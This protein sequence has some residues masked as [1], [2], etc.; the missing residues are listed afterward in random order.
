MSLK[1][2][3]L[4]AENNQKSWEDPLLA[5][6]LSASV[7]GVEAFPVEV[8]ADI[9]FGL[10]G[11]VLVG[12]PDGAVKESRERL[13]AAIKNAGFDFP[14][15]KIT[16]NLAPADIKKEGSGFDL[17]IAATLLAATG[18]IPRER[19]EGVILCG[20]LSL[21]GTVKKV[22]GILPVALLARE[23]GLTLIVPSENAREA[24]LVEG[25]EVWPVKSLGHLLALLLGETLPESVPLPP[26]EEEE[27]VEDMADVMG[28]ESARRALEIAA[29]GGHNLLMLGPP[30]AGKTMLAKRLP[31]LLPPLSYEEALETTRIYSVAGLLSP[32]RPLLKRRPFRAPHHTV[33]DV[34]LIGGG[35]HPKPGEISLAHNGVLFLDELPEFRRNALEALRQ[36]LEDGVVTITRSTITVTYPARFLL[37]ASMNPCKC[38]YYG[39]R[40]RPCQCTP[41]EV[42]RYRNK[43]SGPLLDRIDLQIEVPA[44]DYR[45]LSSDRRGE[46]S[47]II[48]ERVKEARAIQ[49]RRYHRAGKLNAHLSAAEMRKFCALDQEGRR[50]LEQAAQK[51]NLSARAYHRVLKVARTIA[52]MAQ[53]EKILPSHL[54]EA[55]QYRALDR[56]LW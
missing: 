36:P 15:Q 30:G 38:G 48:R 51:L 39:D 29:A 20:E 42:R 26:A 14:S 22:R 37:L 19:L 8:E 17:P 4:P 24:A 47:E 5:K 27:L 34:G 28:Q 55:I 10:P 13:R 32:E 12:L 3:G 18:A 16:V 25:I 45:E 23:R 44:V 56:P 52:D 11:F 9:S 40:R 35:S 7:I 41:Q 53:E 54:L 2:R 31:G 50:L 43:I 46:P 6:T 49:E 33:S 21:D 1:I